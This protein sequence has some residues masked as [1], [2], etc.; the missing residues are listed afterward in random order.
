MRKIINLTLHPINLE[1]EG[2][3]VEIENEPFALRITESIEELGDIITDKGKVKRIR[4]KLTEIPDEQIKELKKKIWNGSNEI[5]IIIVS[6]LAGLK[7]KEDSRLS[8]AEKS[9]IYVIG[10]TIRDEKGR[11]I[12]AKNLVSILDL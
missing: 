7:L 4:K 2:K 8:L 9:A 10:E 1:V 6:Y 11:V 5:N 12:G 3:L